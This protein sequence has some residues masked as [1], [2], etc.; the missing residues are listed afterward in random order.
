MMAGIMQTSQVQSSKEVKYKLGSKEIKINKENSS[1][2]LGERKALRVARQLRLSIKCNG[3]ELVGEVENDFEHIS[4]NN[5]NEIFMNL[6]HL[7]AFELAFRSSGGN[8]H[9]LNVLPVN[10]LS[11]FRNS[12]QL[13]RM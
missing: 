10:V 3:L 13:C 7:L 8:F 1:N 11:R 12:M 5:F 9:P 2:L 4:R 6:L